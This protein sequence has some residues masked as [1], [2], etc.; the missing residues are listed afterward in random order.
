MHKHKQIQIQ[1]NE[2][3]LFD[4][5]SSLIVSPL[6]TLSS[7]PILISNLARC[8]SIIDEISAG[9]GCKTFHVIHVHDT[10]LPN[11]P[12]STLSWRTSPL[13]DSHPRL[14]TTSTLLDNRCWISFTG[15]LHP[16]SPR[17]PPKL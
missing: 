14:A 10:N 7:F 9:S 8:D 4:V 16:F 1:T 13:P 6:S 15:P 5:R 12:I 17:T 3:C 2:S 11:E